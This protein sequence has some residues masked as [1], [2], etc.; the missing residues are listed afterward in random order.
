MMKGA[1]FTGFYATNIREITA[2]NIEGEQI[3]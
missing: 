2:A 3:I 1:A